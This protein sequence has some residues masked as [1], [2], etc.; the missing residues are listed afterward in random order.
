MTKDDYMKDR[1]KMI[2]LE[3]ELYC[4]DIEAETNATMSLWRAYNAMEDALEILEDETN[5]K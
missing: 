1:L 2:R 3:I 5:D 4:I